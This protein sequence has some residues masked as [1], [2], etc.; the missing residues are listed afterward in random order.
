MGTHL[1]LALGRKTDAVSVPSR[2]LEGLRTGSDLYVICVSDSAIREV[3]GRIARVIPQDRI[4][5]HTSGTTP[6]SAISDVYPRTGVLYPMQTFSK[7]VALDYADIPFFIEGSDARVLS[8][9]RRA[10]AFVSGNVTEADS[11]AR[12]DL[13]IASVLSCNFVNHLWT[14]AYDY[15]E[16]KGM[17]F[18]LMVPLVRETVR[19]ISRVSPPEAQTGPAV[20]RDAATIGSHLEALS[21]N[22]ELYELYRVMSESIIARHHN[23]QNT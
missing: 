3:A 20:R 2:T 5:A 19:K 10:A 7:E 17:S 1:S 18:D 12:R 14:L 22:R 23:N 13:H 4:L 11:A 6:L 21:G 8:E 9:L 15:L 16:S